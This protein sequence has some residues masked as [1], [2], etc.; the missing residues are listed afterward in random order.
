MPKGRKTSKNFDKRVK[1]IVDKQLTQEIEEK[2]AVTGQNMT[3][4]STPGIDTGNVLLSSNF[5]KLF[6][7]ITQGVRQYN[8]RVGNEIRLK[9]LDLNMLINFDLLQERV[10]SNS[11]AD[12]SIGVR[13]MILRQK[14]QNSAS[15]AL[16]DFQGNKLLENGLITTAGPASFTGENF[17]LVQAINREQFSVKYDKVIQ[18]Y[19]PF[20]NRDGASPGV[21]PD[22]GTPVLPPRTKVIKHRMKFGKHG[23]KL[24][25]SDAA[26]EFPTNFPYFMVLGYAS[27]ASLL[28]PSDRLIQFSYSSNAKYT[29]A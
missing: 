20:T 9:S 26:A 28:N 1:A 8:S 4:V 16:E 6:P 19:A 5:V 25:Y 23:L 14:D 27:N 13:V 12:S 2:T 10:A 17:N 29:D 22:S 24:T 3:N 15:G 21:P 7:Q 11:E 18:M